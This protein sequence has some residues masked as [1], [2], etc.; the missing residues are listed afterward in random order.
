ME[1]LLQYLDK[2]FSGAKPFWS[3]IISIICFIIFPDKA[4]MWSAFALVGAMALDIIT[5]YWAL[6]KKAGGYRK[7]VQTRAIFSATFWTK[8]S[9]KIRT[10]LVVAILSGLA[11]RV[12]F[13]EQIG[14]FLGTFA[15]TMMFLRE[16]QSIFENLEDAGGDVGWLI[17]WTKRK[18][19]HVMEQEGEITDDT[20]E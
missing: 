17:R 11:Y 5:K 12:T 9:I 14:I 6:A 16:A 3:G 19:D 1:Q 20:T 4:Y 2:V 10:Y 15:Y 13:M 7:A 18:Q 8:T